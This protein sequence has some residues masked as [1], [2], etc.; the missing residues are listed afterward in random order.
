MTTTDVKRLDFLDGLRALAIGFVMLLHYWQMTW[1]DFSLVIGNFKVD[2]NFLA[3]PGS[4]GVSIFF[5]VSG[6]CLYLSFDRAPD[7]K[8]YFSKRFFKIVPSYV[9]AI[10]LIVAFGWFKFT[11]AGD[12]SKH[13]LTHLFF[14]HNWFSDTYGSINGVFWSLAVEVQFYAIFPFIYPLVK[15]Y[16]FLSYL[17]ATALGQTLRLILHFKN[18]QTFEF[19]I[20]Q[21]PLVVDIFVG[22]MAAGVWISRWENR[23]VRPRFF[24]SKLFSTGLGLAGMVALL[25]CFEWAHVKRYDPGFSKLQ[26]WERTPLILTLIVF[27]FG[28]YFAHPTWNQALV[29]PI[30][31]FLSRISYNLYIWHQLLGHK[32]VELNI[33]TP[34]G[35][36]H[37]DVV[38]QTKF[39]ALAVSLSFASSWILTRYFEEPIL[40]W[41]RR[42]NS[43]KRKGALWPPFRKI[44]S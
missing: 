40:N 17:A 1:Y 16:P 34:N 12:F 41:A 33:F 43:G 21:M 5:F 2:L 8:S 15:R 23:E 24:N 19:W 22:G 10:A 28:S 36:P 18:P 27:S 39:F 4:M 25:A 11:T 29:N 32:I 44:A 13:I 3:T 6:F 20:N 31:K 42:R 9:L 30:F 35:D 7:L 26:I 37:D 38:W 14:I